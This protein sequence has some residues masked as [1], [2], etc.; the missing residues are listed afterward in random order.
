MT[1]NA[2]FGTTC[3]NHFCDIPLLRGFTVQYALTMRNRSVKIRNGN[4]LR[5][6]LCFVLMHSWLNQ[7]V[8]YQRAEANCHERRL[9]EQYICII[10]MKMVSSESVGHSV[11]ATGHLFKS[12]RHRLCHGVNS[13]LHTAHTHRHLLNNKNAVPANWQLYQSITSHHPDETNF[14]LVV[15]NKFNC[16]SRLIAST[17]S[18]FQM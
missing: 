9:N 4:A 18:W 13:A 1:K 10:H 7:T 12:S 16:R 3:K 11:P 2:T 17:K 5:A 8:H 15:L 14:L 6:H